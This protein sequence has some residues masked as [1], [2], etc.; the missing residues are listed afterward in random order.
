MFYKDHA[1]GSM[2]MDC[3]KTNTKA[4]KAREYAIAVV[5]NC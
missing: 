5:Q 3:S 2:R 4:G 1:D